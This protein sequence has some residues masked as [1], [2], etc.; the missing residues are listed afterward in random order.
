MYKILVTI[1]VYHQGVAL[2]QVCLS[3]KG[4]VAADKAYAR[5]SS[6]DNNRRYHRNVERLY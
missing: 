3:F 4:R 2:S 5:L 1:Y 6:R